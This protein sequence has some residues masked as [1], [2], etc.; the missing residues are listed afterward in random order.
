MCIKRQTQYKLTINGT[1]TH[2][3]PAW[4][5][6]GTLGTLT[7]TDPFNASNAQI[8]HY[9]YD[10]MARLASVDCGATK[11]QQNFTYDPFGNITKS[12]PSGGAGQ[13]FLPGYNESN[14]RY[15]DGATYDA[16]GNLMNDGTDHVYTWDADGHPVTLDSDTLLYDALGRE[17]EVFKG[18]A[19]TEFVFGPTGK[20][21]LMTGQTQTKAFV[22]LPGGTQVKYSG[23]A[24][25]TYRLPDWLGS[26][27][28]GSNPNR[29]YSW[30]VAFAPFGEMYAQSGVPAWSFT[31][32]EGTADT[33]SDEYDFLARKLHSAQG[34][35]ISPDPAGSSAADAA[36]PQSWNLYAYVLNNP[37]IAIDPNGL[38]CV[39]L[40]NN[41]DGVQSID[42]D[43][44]FDECTG[45]DANGN[46]NGGFWVP[47]T[48]TKVTDIDMDIGAIGAYSIDP[49]YGVLFTASA[50]GDYGV[51]Y[52]SVTVPN[53]ASGLWPDG[54]P[55]LA[56]ADHRNWFQ[57][58]MGAVDTW[59]MNHD[60]G[61]SAFACSVIP[62][63]VNDINSV[64]AQLKGKSAPRPN[65]AV[66]GGNQSALWT[67]GVFMPNAN[68]TKAGSNHYAGEGPIANAPAATAAG[69]VAAGLDYA[70][71]AAQCAQ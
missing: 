35:W 12:V 41:A 56:G 55:T 60:S 17:V 25:S 48:V 65:D 1:A 58:Q 71:A 52:N 24:I 63:G 59:M 34:R 39:Y 54:Y 10:D 64:A 8:C 49:T 31:G 9:G 15:T 68:S 14:N 21:A 36:N 16:D 33:V 44:N 51:S 62:S 32:E 27:R 45:P 37:L 46:P 61:L 69:G 43:S 18:G 11:W 47:G 19:Y 66:D 4:N 40:N 30:G 13:P 67:K 57:R 29:T 70:N 3:D 50:N 53:N 28:V 23:N 26:F 22:P 7:I 38:D 6:N 42:H 5:P 20:L 2:G